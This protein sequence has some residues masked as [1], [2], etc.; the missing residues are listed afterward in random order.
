LVPID[1]STY[2]AGAI[3]TAGYKSTKMRWIYR[4]R[5]LNAPELLPNTLPPS[6][7]TEGLAASMGHTDPKAA[8]AGGMPGVY[9]NGLQRIGF[10]ITA[11]TNWMGDDAMLRAASVRIKAPVIFGDTTF[12][13]ASVTATRRNGD[14]GFVDITLQADNQFG[15]TTATGTATVELHIPTS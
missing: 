4:D 11:V 8:A 12:V 10:M 6:Y 5:A 7:F 3:G 1:M 14:A 13:K 2:Y 15:D 9:D